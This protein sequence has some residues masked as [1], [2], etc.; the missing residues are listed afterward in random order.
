MGTILTSA[1]IFVS[2]MNKEITILVVGVMGKLITLSWNLNPTNIS[3]LVGVFRIFH[4]FI[5]FLN[6]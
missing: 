2:I 4:S 3:L 5:P 6:S 1:Y